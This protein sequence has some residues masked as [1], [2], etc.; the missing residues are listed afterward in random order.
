MFVARFAAYS[1][2]FSVVV[3]VFSS[4]F[5]YVVFGFAVVLQHV[6]LAIGYGACVEGGKNHWG[7]TTGNLSVY[8]HGPA[9]GPGRGPQACA[10]GV[11]AGGRSRLLPNLGELL[12]PQTRTLGFFSLGFW[13]DREW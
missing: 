13:T 9:P 1:V 12:H 7:S 4:G 5:A 6:T 10:S 11:A 8:Q 2:L 3:G